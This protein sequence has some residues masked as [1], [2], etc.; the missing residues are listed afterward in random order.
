[1]DRFQIESRSGHME[2]LGNGV[3]DP[4]AGIVYLEVLDDLEHISDQMADMTHSV[5]ETTSS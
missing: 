5:L 4:N 1:M 3:C 2:R